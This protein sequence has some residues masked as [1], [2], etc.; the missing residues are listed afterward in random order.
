MALFLIL[1]KE[2]FTCLAETQRYINIPKKSWT[3]AEFTAKQN[4]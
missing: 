3:K 1:I 2:D 4:V